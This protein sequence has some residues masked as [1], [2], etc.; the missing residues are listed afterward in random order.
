MEVDVIYG[1]DGAMKSTTIILAI[2]SSVHAVDSNDLVKEIS[3]AIYTERPG[4]RLIQ[5][6]AGE[7]SFGRDLLLAVDKVKPY[8]TSDR[9]PAAAM[10]AQL[11][12]NAKNAQRINMN[13]K[14]ATAYIPTATMVLTIDE[15]EAIKR[16][17]QE[18]VR[19]PTS[20]M[21]LMNVLG[22]LNLYIVEEST[23]A[24]Y[25]FDHSIKAFDKTSIPQEENENRKTD[26]LVKA[27]SM[28]LVKR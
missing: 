27:L 12:Q 26:N 22:L 2:K 9:S 17:C 7:I 10:F 28:A 1:A 19:E 24:L 20:A 25:R 18:D 15:I 13:G 16:Q 3:N 8:F 4:F 23:G 11:L 14:S 21:K 6:Y 5:W